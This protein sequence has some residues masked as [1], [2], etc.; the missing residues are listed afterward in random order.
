MGGRHVKWLRAQAA[1]ARRA[2]SSAAGAVSAFVRRNLYEI[3]ASAL[4]AL[5]A[6]IFQH[7]LGA[8]LRLPLAVVRTEMQHRAAETKRREGEALRSSCIATIGVATVELLDGH[9][10]LDAEVIFR[11]SHDEPL[12]IRHLAELSASGK[13]LQQGWIAGEGYRLST[14]LRKSWQA[15]ETATSRCAGVLTEGPTPHLVDALVL[16]VKE[17]EHAAYRLW[18]SYGRAMSAR[19]VPD[20]AELAV[21]QEEYRRRFTELGRTLEF[22]VRAGTELE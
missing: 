7:A 11:L 9:L 8:L 5:G 2:A 4:S 12:T 14:R 22:A 18:E 1:R 17:S 19:G 13:L 15:F 21:A 10:V 16:A 3:G 6:A 20:V